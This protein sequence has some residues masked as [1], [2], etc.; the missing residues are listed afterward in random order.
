MTR[1][2]VIHCSMLA[3][4]M[5]KRAREVCAMLPKDEA[6]QYLIALLVLGDSERKNGQNFFDDR[7]GVSASFK[8]LQSLCLRG[9]YL[10][11]KEEA[12]IKRLPFS[13]QA[14]FEFFMGERWIRE[15]FGKWLR[16]GRKDKIITAIFGVPKK[17][18][19]SYKLA[20]E[21]QQR[22]I[23]IAASVAAY[24]KKRYSFREAVRRTRADLKKLGVE[25]I[26]EESIR[27]IYEKISA[28]HYPIVSYFLDSV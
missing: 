6:L 10:E 13:F 26:S 15:L 16:E 1:K 22:D 25:R 14:D 12:V 2:N 21:N 9:L 23:K 24:K 28:G 17:G 27:S 3:D 8:I 20:V 19:R 5:V 18:R 11:G 4:K 7:Y